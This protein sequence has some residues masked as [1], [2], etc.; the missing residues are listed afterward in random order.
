MND[1]QPAPG[2][3]LLPDSTDLITSIHF[4]LI[5]LFALLAV[6]I[7]LIGMRRR[8]RRKA[9]ERVVEDRLEQAEHEAPPPSPTPAP[10]ADAAPPPPTARDMPAAPPPVTPAPPP[11]MPAP[12]P[13]GDPLAF[14][15][16]DAPA[17]LSDEPIAAAAPQDASPAAEAASEPAVEAIDPLT[18]TAGDPAAGPLTQLKGL[19]PKVQALLAA[20]GIATV[21]DLA[22]LSDAEAAALDADL[23]PFAGRMARDRWLDQARLLAAGDRAGFEAQFGRL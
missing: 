1:A 19:G 13:L 11:V 17:P 16:P 10:V 6:A 23:G 12:P 14:P 8:A 2:A 9:A 5:G 21:G 15:E 3:S 20:R 7:I 4:V 22:R 18:G